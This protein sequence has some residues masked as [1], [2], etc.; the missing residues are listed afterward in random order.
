MENFEKDTFGR[1]N[2]LKGISAGAVS[3]SLFG[4]SEKPR[5]EKFG[6]MTMRVNPKTGEKVS[7]LGFG[8]MRCLACRWG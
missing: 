3:A 5:E 4:C 8:C 6:P 2:F 7:L 1:R